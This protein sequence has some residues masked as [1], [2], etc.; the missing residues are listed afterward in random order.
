MG[1]YDFTPVQNAECKTQPIILNALITSLIA[2][3]SSSASGSASSLPNCTDISQMIVF[4]SGSVIEMVASG[5]PSTDYTRSGYQVSSSSQLLLAST[6]PPCN[7]TCT[8]WSSRS[9]TFWAD[10][11]QM[12]LYPSRSTTSLNVSKG[13]RRNQLRLWDFIGWLSI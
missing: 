10:L 9:P 4:P 3:Q 1:G 7:I 13:M 5:S 12:P 11:R 2:L 8:T 6:A